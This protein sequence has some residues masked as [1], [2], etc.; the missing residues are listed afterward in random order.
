MKAKNVFL[1][2]MLLAFLTQVAYPAEVKRTA[3]ID[4]ITGH[5][6]VKL[7]KEKRWSPAKIGMALNEG[8]VIRTKQ[9]SVVFISI[10]GKGESAE[11][12]LSESSFLM[13]FELVEDDEAKTESTFL[14]LSMGEIVISKKKTR[15]VTAKFEVKTPTSIVSVQEGAA[16][17]SIKVE[18]VE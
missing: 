1:I 16:R 7:L 2:I 6:E 13:F 14:D 3:K 8:D 10:N 15:D 9:S 4:S 17:F 12:E 11:I 18:Q 5:A